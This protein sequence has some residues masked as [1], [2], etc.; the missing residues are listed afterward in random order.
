[1]S[2]EQAYNFKRIDE[3]V[4]TAGLLDKQQLAELSDEGYETV[5]NLLPE[6]SEYAVADEAGI[7]TRQGLDYIYI[8]VDFGNPCE[9]DFTEFEQ[10]METHRDQKLL[11]H[12][13][14]NFRVSAF[15]GIYARQR[16]GWS[17]AEARA[18]IASIWSPAE[19]P[20]WAQFISGYLGSEG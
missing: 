17:S 15:Y 20:P 14:A 19:H 11:I 13:A 6:D 3:R 12:C 10:A 5:I 16:L 2:I 8:P 18:H 7:V 4:A 9:A 1:M